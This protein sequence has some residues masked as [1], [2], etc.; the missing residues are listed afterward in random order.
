MTDPHARD[1][2]G[3]DGSEVVEP[4]AATPYDPRTRD[5]YTLVS[6]RAAPAAA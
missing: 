6:A 2:A 5:W 3:E 4:W 1:T